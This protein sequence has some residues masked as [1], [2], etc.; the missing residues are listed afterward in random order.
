MRLAPRIAL[1]LLIATTAHAGSISGSVRVSSK[2]PERVTYR[3]YAGR[4]SSLPAPVHAPRGLVTD[5]VVYVDELPEGAH[6]SIPADMPRLAQ[7]GQAFE[8][9]VV[10][11]PAGGSVDFPNFDPVY[12]NVF[13]VSPVKRFDLGKYPR[14]GSRSVTFP[15]PGVVNVFCDIHADMSA[16]ILIVPQQAWAR[17]AADGRF[18][19]DGL[20]PGR[21]TLRWWHPD[22]EGGSR[23]VDVPAEGVVTKDVEL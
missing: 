14:G 21:Y 2:L 4:A 17:P 23:T 1:L 5:A 15:K 7:R 6:V 13:S 9:R 10:V 16:F 22:F 11:V 3:P 8:P 12:H 18:E 20:P 19:L